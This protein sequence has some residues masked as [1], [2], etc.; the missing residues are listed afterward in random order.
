MLGNKFSKNWTNAMR[1]KREQNGRQK[2]Q[3]LFLDKKPNR[4][5]MPVFFSRLLAHFVKSKHDI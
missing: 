4:I 1:G 5:K 2:R 3:A